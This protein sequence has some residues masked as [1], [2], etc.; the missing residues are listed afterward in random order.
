[1]TLA[2]RTGSRE[3]TGSRGIA[4]SDQCGAPPN[5][6]TLEVRRLFSSDGHSC[7]SAE[8]ASRLSVVAWIEAANA[9]SIRAPA[10]LAAVRLRN[11][12]NRTSGSTGSRAFLTSLILAFRTVSGSRADTPRPESRAAMVASRLALSNTTRHSNP[13]LRNKES[14]LSRHHTVLSHRM[15]GRTLNESIEKSVLASHAKRDLY[16]KTGRPAIRV[17]SLMTKSSS[18]CVSRN[19]S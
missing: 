4:H 18:P 10:L 9:S 2:R 13:A 19:S 1:M 3:C 17:G 5:S 14:I 6:E 12:P 8:C 15:S 7:V 11:I 16:S